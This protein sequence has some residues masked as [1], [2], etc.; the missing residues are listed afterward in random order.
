M[1]IVE[2]TCII[3]II[4]PVFTRQS[5]ISVEHSKC[6][7][8]YQLGN[9]VIHTVQC[10]KRNWNAQKTDNWNVPTSSVV[11]VIEL[12]CIRLKDMIG[13]NALSYDAY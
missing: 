11:V 7:E 2:Y 12:R 13:N 4:C 3:P 9:L 6:C 8:Y 10:F 5:D 1:Y